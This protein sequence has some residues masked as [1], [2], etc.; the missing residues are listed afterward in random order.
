M[1]YSFNSQNSAVPVFE[2]R[3]K[4]KKKFRNSFQKTANEQRETEEHGSKQRALGDARQRLWREV[5]EHSFSEIFTPAVSCSS[6]FNTWIAAFQL[7]Y[8]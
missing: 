8:R 3:I 7:A 6:W 1:V 5:S 2:V 4:Q